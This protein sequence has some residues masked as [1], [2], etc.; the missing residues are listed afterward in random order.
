MFQRGISGEEGLVS[1]VSGRTATV[2]IQAGE[3]CDKC[4][5]CTR[6]SSTRMV[7]DAV[8]RDRV[9]VGD[10]VRVVIKPGMIIGSAALLYI[11]PLA[12]LVAGYFAGRSVF[13]PGPPGKDELYPALS[14]IVCFFAAF[15]PIRLYDKQRMKKKRFG[16]YV[17]RAG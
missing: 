5:L 4:G 14:A 7:V 15:V 13:G 6:I 8:V 11:F 3:G 9:S 12:G 16:V 17:E 1:A 10:R 2:V